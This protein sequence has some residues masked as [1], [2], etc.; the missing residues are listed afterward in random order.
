M[1]AVNKV[2]GLKNSSLEDL[3]LIEQICA[4]M[5]DVFSRV[6]D[7]SNIASTAGTCLYASILLQQSLDRFG[8]CESVVR[9]GDG[10]ND[11]GAQDAQFRWHGHYWV[12]GI[13]AGGTAF[14]A[15]IT[16]DQ[17]GWPAVVVLP[18]AE[19]RSRYQPGDDDVV[20]TAVEDEIDRMLKGAFAD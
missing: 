20:G 18:L 16:G 19:A 6:L 15:D 2:R 8:Q 4:N 1:I 10:A 11:G 13:T 9:G 5:R 14:L 7:M 12:E 3:K 17:F